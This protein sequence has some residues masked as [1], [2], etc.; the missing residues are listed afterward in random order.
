MNLVHLAAP[1]EKVDEVTLEVGEG[2]SSSASPPYPLRLR[3]HGHREFT[4]LLEPWR[5]PEPFGSPRRDCP[6]SEGG[7]ASGAPV[8]QHVLGAVSIIE[9][10]LRT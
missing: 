10:R 3:G 9:W 5:S 7:C 8:L 4:V 6:P 1:P 2:A